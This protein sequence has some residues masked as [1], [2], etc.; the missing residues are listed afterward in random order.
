MSV[1]RNWVPTIILFAISVHV[2]AEKAPK[3]S[4]YEHLDLFSRVLDIVEKQYYRNV[5]MEKL[6]EGAIRGILQTLDPHSRYLDKEALKKMKS[7]TSGKFGGLGVEVTSQD[8]VIIVITPIEGTPAFNAGIKNGDKIVEIEGESIQGIGLEDAVEK[9]RGKPGSKVNIGLLRRGGEKIE[10]ISLTRKIVRIRPVKSE[11][12]Q[13][14]YAYIRLTQFQSE[15]SKYVREHLKRLTKK[16]KTLHGI[17]FDLRSNPGG[18]LD[19]A[20]KVSSIFLKEGIVVSTEARDPKQKEVRMVLKDG[21]KDIKTPLVVLINGASASASEIVAGALKDHGRA[22]IMGGQS[23]GK[24]SVQTVLD[25]TE[26]KGLKLT[27][28]QY[29]TPRGG[30]IQAKGITPDITIPEFDENWSEK[31]EDGPVYLREQDLRNHLSATIE[32]PEE[33]KL[34]IERKKRQR[35][36]RQKRIKREQMQREGKPG[37]KRAHD[38][39]RVFDPKADFQVYSAINHLKSFDFYQRF[40]GPGKG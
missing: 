17:V 24:G 35:L 11:L 22:I 12:L 27:I 16:A 4:K 1:I 40:K 25:L 14:K 33:K 15:S 8:G 21:F 9:M 18:L 13:K 26:D 30:K 34:R 19:E 23:F 28:Q 36:Q 31:V 32:T 3:Q 6:M 5:N 39:P 37:E 10:Q 2:L 7:D 38:L 20:V 29:M